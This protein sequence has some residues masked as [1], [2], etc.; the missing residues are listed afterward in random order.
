MLRIEKNWLF[1]FHSCVLLLLLVCTSAHETYRRRDQLKVISF[2]SCYVQELGTVTTLAS[3]IAVASDKFGPSRRQ[4]RRWWDHYKCFKQ[5]PWDTQKEWKALARKAGFF[6]RTNKFREWHVEKMREIL[7]EHPEYFLDEFVRELYIRTGVLYHP[8]SVWKL[9]YYKMNYRLKTYSEIAKQRNLDE[10]AIYKAALLILVTHPNQVV[11]ADESHK[12]RNASR[13]K[14]AYSRKGIELILHRWFVKTVRY[15]FLAACNID[16]F[17][18]SALDTVRRDKIE[19]ASEA[20][21]GASGTM[22][23]EIFI[24]WVRFS[25][26]PCLGNY[27]KDEPNSIVVMDN[28]ATHMDPEVERIIRSRGAILLY[29][30]AFSPDISPIEKMFSVYKAALKRYES[31]QQSDWLLAHYKAVNQVTPEIARQ[32]FAKCGVPGA[33]ELIDAESDTFLYMV[34]LL[35]N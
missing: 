22:N 17:I 11:F 32:Q 7:D 5:L 20:K 14:K 34:A 21:E 31:L 29:T 10:V 26:A 13:R 33:Q 19:D 15:T 24:R 6:I 9:L 25:L 2:V 30:A 8:S 1:L 23:R 28:A 12:D 18:G 3:I 16:G 27:E 35:L 4:I